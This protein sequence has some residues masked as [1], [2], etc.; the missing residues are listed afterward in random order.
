MDF[1]SDSE[2]ESDG[3]ASPVN[4][5]LIM[6]ASA[7]DLDAL[8]R[9]IAEGCDVDHRDVRG[10]SA[11]HHLCTKSSNP[12]QCVAALIGAGADVNLPSALSVYQMP[13][14]NSA[15][16]FCGPEIV[17]ALI[18]A[19]ADVNHTP[20]E[21]SP[22]RRAAIFGCDKNVMLLLAA[23][24]VVDAIAPYRRDGVTTLETPLDAAIRFLADQLWRGDYTRT[25]AHLL[26]AG[27]RIPTHLDRLPPYIDKV[28]LA[29][30]FTLYARAHR[31]RLAAIF[32]PTFTQ[33]PA[34]VVHHI[35][36]IWA[37]V[38]GH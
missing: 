38:G 10:N 3:E 12:I 15:V 18:D 22:L 30:G 6:A 24:A 37:D 21:A 27:A 1:D 2:P 32:I 4:R 7:C 31:A 29:G 14:I 13:P 33:L 20:P 23:G 25:F 34:E 19:G 5:A 9:A 11:L 28:A 8:R 26:R 35:V 36:E 17:K 16:R